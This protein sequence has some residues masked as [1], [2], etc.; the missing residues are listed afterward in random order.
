VHNTRVVDNTI[1]SSI[2][3]KYTDL[4][5]IHAHAGR[6]TA[7]EPAIAHRWGGDRAKIIKESI[8]TKH[9]PEEDKKRYYAIAEQDVDLE[10][11]LR[12][13]LTVTFDDVT[14]RVTTLDFK[15]RSM[16]I[17]P[18]PIAVAL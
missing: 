13:E 17:R 4:K 11:N 7:R 5:V 12:I 9:L 10:I 14:K 18:S 15:V 1:I 3:I 2:L 16:S 8:A 6:I